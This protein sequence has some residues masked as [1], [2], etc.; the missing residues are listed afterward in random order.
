MKDVTKKSYETVRLQIVKL[1]EDVITESS[2]LLDE[3][4]NDYGN[5][6]G[7]DITLFTS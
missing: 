2:M 6:W 3:N 7:W 4:G 5:K 1:D